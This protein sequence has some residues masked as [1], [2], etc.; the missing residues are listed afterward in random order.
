[1]KEMQKS[2]QIQFAES[3]NLLELQELLKSADLPYK[4]IEEH[5]HNFVF[6]KERDDLIGCVGLEICGAIALLRSLAVVENHRNKGWGY[7]LTKEILQFAMLKKITKV[8]LLT[9]T[10]ERFFA[11]LGFAQIQRDDAPEAI[12]LTS[13]FSS[14]CPASAILMFK[15]LSAG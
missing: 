15:D 13:Q 9:T 10:A 4:D 6:I 2:T 14:L 11:R 5:I 12:R 8:Y 1:V 3:K 7:I